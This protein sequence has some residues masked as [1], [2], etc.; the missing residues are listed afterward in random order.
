MKI[1]TLFVCFLLIPVFGN[2]YAISYSMPELKGDRVISLTDGDIHTIEADKNE[3]LLDIARRYNLGQMEI[4]R[5]NPNLDR[6][7]IKKGDV[8]RL[9]NKRILPD[10]PHN[11]I[12]LNLSE[13]RMYYYPS[14]DK[15]KVLTYA[16]GIGRQDWQTPLGKTRIIRKIKNPSWNPPASIRR[17]HAAEGDPLPP[18]VLPGPHNPLGTRALHLALPG[19]YRIHGTDIDKVYGIGMQVTHGCVRMYPEDIEA[20]FD[21][22]TPGTAVYIVKQPI[23]VGWLR[24][25]LY[26]EAHPDLE[27][28]EKTK[29]QRYEL[30]LS[31]IEKANNGQMP[32]FDQKTLN[33][34]LDKLDGEPVAL[35]EGLPPLEETPANIYEQEP[36]SIPEPAEPQS[37]PES[38][39]IPEPSTKLKQKPDVMLVKKPA[40]KKSTVTPVRKTALKP[41]YKQ[42]SKSTPKSQAK[43]EPKIVSKSASKNTAK[44]VAKL[45]TKTA[46]KLSNRVSSKVITKTAAVSKKKLKPEG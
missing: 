24:N 22:V 33:E 19:E 37:I 31:L 30:A 3:T 43:T 29:D 39:P 38:Q 10:T 42:A 7:L 17:E 34:A 11:G 41:A 40:S 20:L 27:G 13:Y 18:V 25:T 4:V 46:T 23:K 12:T 45:T 9:P 16:H 6:W 32:E 2:A 35:Y 1:R 5:L 21:M 36:Q 44:T 26:L 15:N 14:W 28:E 8:V